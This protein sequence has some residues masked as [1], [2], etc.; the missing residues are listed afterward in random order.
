M[1][2]LSCYK[3]VAERSSGDADVGPVCSSLRTSQ[4]RAS[5]LGLGGWLISDY[6]DVGDE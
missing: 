5:V 6:D 1:N 2:R 3:Q 4:F